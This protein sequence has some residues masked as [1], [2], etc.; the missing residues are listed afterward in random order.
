MIG[1]LFLTQHPFGVLLYE[2]GKLRALG[3]FERV[4]EA[5]AVEGLVLA[6]FFVVFVLDV[7]RG[8]VVGQQHDLVAEQVA[9]RTS[10]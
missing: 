4:G 2:H 1:A 3:Q 6:H 5:D 9:G 7:Q 8:D 10:A